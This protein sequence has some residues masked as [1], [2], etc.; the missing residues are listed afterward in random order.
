MP[1]L[2]TLL[3]ALYLFCGMIMIE[4]ESTV[5]F[6]VVDKLVALFFNLEKAEKKSDSTFVLSESQGKS[7]GL[8]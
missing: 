1:P 5:A 4:K 7:N 6:S 2:N 3:T 8:R